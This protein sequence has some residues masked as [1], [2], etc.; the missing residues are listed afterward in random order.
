MLTQAGTTG[1]GLGFSYSIPSVVTASNVKNY[2]Q[3]TEKKQDTRFGTTA[4]YVVKPARRSTGTEDRFYV[5]GLENIKDSSNNTT[6]RWYNGAMWSLPST[7]VTSKDFGRGR[8]NTE[9][10]LSKYKPS[11]QGGYGDIDTRDLWYNIGTQVSDGWFVPSNGEWAA[12]AK[13]FDI[14]PSTYG[15]YGLSYV[16][17]TSMSFDEYKAY[18]AEFSAGDI[19]QRPIG[20]GSEK[21]ARLSTTF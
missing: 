12:F 17:W 15:S 20:G 16:Y 3:S 6:L 9:L 19:Y 1:T 10:I 5:M 8:A 14:K 21:Y 4:R 11:S 7:P 2:V 13:A 18:A